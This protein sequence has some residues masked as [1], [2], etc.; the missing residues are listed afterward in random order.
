[1]TTGTLKERTNKA[2][3]RTELAVVM[4][5]IF[6]VVTAA[7]W[8]TDKS[9]GDAVPVR[10]QLKWRHQFQFAGFYAALEK[11]YYRD[12]GFA[13]TITPG[14]PGTDPVDTVLNGRADFGL[15]PSE[16]VLR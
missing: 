9:S 5:I 11:G 4:S 10:L 1:M 7:I 2:L 3:W 15:R 13:V 12:A 8:A 14:T 16:L 6:F